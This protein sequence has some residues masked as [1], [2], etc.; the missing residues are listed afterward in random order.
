VRFKRPARSAAVC[1]RMLTVCTVIA[2][3]RYYPNGVRMHTTV[4]PSGTAPLV[5]DIT[6]R[7]QR[8]LDAI[9]A[10]AAEV[11]RTLRIG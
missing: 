8:D 11:L 10:P 2:P 9:E 1:R 3:G 5:I 4:L 7:T 6:G